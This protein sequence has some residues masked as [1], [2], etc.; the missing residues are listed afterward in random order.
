MISFKN[1]NNS[2]PYELFF[3]YYEKALEE[4]QK[5]I[6]AIAISSF[7]KKLNEVDSRFVNLKFIDNNKWIFFSNYNSPK[8]NQFKTHQQISALFFWSSIDVQIRIKAEIQRT[9]KNYNNE[10]FYNRSKDKNAL[11]ISSLQSQKIDSY[12]EVVKEY[13]KVKKIHDLSICPQYWGGFAFIPYYFEFW[14][15]HKSRL[16]KRKAFSKKNKEWSEFFLQP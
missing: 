9:S 4:N 1:N 13:N 5:N 11:A 6:D 8:S 3:R 10:Y 12:G 2:K 15:G 7:D 14:E 16:N